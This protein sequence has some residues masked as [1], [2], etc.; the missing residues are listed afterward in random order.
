MSIWKEERYR[1]LQGSYPVIFLSFADI[2]GATFEK[3]KK[4]I[5]HALT[6]LYSS[7]IC[8]RDEMLLNEK[9]LAFFDSVSP[10]MPENVAVLALKHLSDFMSRYYG[11]KF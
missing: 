11:K 10:D 7:H 2:K 8:L 3:T 9:E 5:L 4:G 1:A 6:R